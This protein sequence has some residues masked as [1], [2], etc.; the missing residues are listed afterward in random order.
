MVCFQIYGEKDGDGFFWGEASGRAGHVPCNM[1]SE[2]QVDDERM[3]QEMLRDE[4]HYSSEKRCGRKPMARTPN[5]LLYVLMRG[6]V[7]FHAVALNTVVEH[8]LLAN[9]AGGGRHSLGLVCV[10]ASTQPW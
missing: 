6:C 10:T 8:V 7:L 5:P 3:A 2:V 1:V 9:T 4:G